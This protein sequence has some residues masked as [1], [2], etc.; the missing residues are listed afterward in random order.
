MNS[1]TDRLK[2]AQWILERNLS[3]IAASEVKTGAIVAID[4]GMLGSLA[5]NFS[6]AGSPAHTAWV[7]FSSLVA[8]T[9]LSFGV[10]CCAMAVVPRLAGPK[11]SFIFFGAIIKQQPADYVEA[12]KAAS[13]DDLLD[14]CLAQIHRNAEIASAKFAW[15]RAAMCWSFSAILPW[16]GALTLLIKK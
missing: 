3:W 12:F 4:T 6:S 5:S 9:C 1:E 16:V 10:F 14:D 7:I 13:L 15:V 8:V 11:S 2:P